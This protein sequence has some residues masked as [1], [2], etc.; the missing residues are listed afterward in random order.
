[1]WGPGA[2]RRIPIP[3]KTKVGE[4]L[5]ADTI[6]AVLGLVQMS[7]VEIHTWNCV[8]PDIERPDRVIFDLDPDEAVPWSDVVDAA[9]LLRKELA[10][11]G[12]ESFVKTTGGKGLHVVVPIARRHSWPEVRRFCEAFARQQAQQASVQAFGGGEAAI[13]FAQLVVHMQAQRLEGPGRGVDAVL[14]MLLHG[15]FSNRFAISIAASAASSPL[16]P[17]LP[18]ARASASSKRSA[19]STP[20]STGTR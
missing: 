13:Q 18:P 3:E 17:W 19:A 2:L 7:I 4:Y 11:I 6:E 16:L 20:L 5:I 14:A 1:M 9:R 10:A 8:D 15:S 12:H